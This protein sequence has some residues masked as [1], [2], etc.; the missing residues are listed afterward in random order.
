[1]VIQTSSQWE[2]IEN[3]FEETIKIGK[4]TFRM[5]RLYVLEVAKKIFEKYVKISDDIADCK[6]S[7]FRVQKKKLSSL[8]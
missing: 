1:M 4:E 2:L 6:F 7:N 3:R 5:H 8:Y